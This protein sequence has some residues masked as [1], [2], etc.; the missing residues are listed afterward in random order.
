M[1]YQPPVYAQDLAGLLAAE[2]ITRF[3]AVGTSLGGI[4]TM[5]LAASQPGWWRVPCSTISAR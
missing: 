5:M 2:K 3:I 1:T 4:L